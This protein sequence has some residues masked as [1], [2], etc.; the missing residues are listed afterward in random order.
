M[1]VTYSFAEIGV[2][3]CKPS[4]PSDR[5]SPRPRLDV[6][7]SVDFE[8]QD[9]REI[10]TFIRGGDGA[11]HAGQRSGYSAAQMNELLKS[12]T[13]ASPDGPARK[14]RRCALRW[15]KG[16]PNS[17]CSNCNASAL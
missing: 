4:V 9:R 12:L 2:R 3:C 17:I 15:M 8:G 6:L 11:D 1:K 7:A 13:D 10:A 14:S 16:S 5:R